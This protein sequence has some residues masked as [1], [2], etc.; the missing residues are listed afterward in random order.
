VT[1]II[2]TTG[3][4]ADGFR[5]LQKT[6]LSRFFQTSCDGTNDHNVTVTNV[7]NCDFA[8][9]GHNEDSYRKLQKSFFRWLG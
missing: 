7:L 3:H 5:K 1:V 6:S 2:V 8:K 4:N 9:S